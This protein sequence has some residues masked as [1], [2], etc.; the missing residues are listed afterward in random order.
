MEV[1]LAFFDRKRT[2]LK[3]YDYNRKGLYFITICTNERK[4]ILSHIVGDGDLDV[5]KIE[6]T[7]IGKIVEKNILISNKNERIEIDKYVIMPNHIHLIVFVNKCDG[8]VKGT[9]VS[10]SPTNAII[11]HFV[12]TFKRF[13]NAEIGE[14][15]F[16]RSYHDHIIRNEDDYINISKYILSNPARWEKDCFFEN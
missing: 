6:L 9:P 10:P 13:C 14:K 12:S 3:G 8:E 2:R 5:P 4:C 15:V 7:S 16:Q 11:P 1:E